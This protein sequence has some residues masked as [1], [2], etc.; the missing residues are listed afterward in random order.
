[1]IVQAVKHFVCC[2][3]HGFIC[4][5]GSI[6]NY[7]YAIYVGSDGAAAPIARQ[8]S[9]LRS[10]LCLRTSCFV[11]LA[12]DKRYRVASACEREVTGGDRDL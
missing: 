1:M 3:V 6:S 9:S 5:A 12:L 11:V 10:Q 8:R 4:T 2:F 7:T